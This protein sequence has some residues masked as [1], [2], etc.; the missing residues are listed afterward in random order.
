MT[1]LIITIVLKICGIV[2]AV[3]NTVRTLKTWREKQTALLY[4]YQFVFRRSGKRPEIGRVK[5]IMYRVAR[6]PMPHLWQPEKAPQKD[7][8]K[9]S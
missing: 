5:R 4:E 9:V 3:P 8:S 7:I 6:M 1:F 2:L